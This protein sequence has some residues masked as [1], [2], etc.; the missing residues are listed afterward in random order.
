MLRTFLVTV[1]AVVPFQCLL[2]GEDAGT[3][4]KWEG[5]WQ[6]K[7][8]QQ[9]KELKCVA[10]PVGDGGWQATF[11]GVCN[12]RFSFQVNMRGRAVGDKVVF[13]GNT[14]LG[15]ENGGTYTWSGSI[16]G[17]LFSGKYKSTGGK[18]GTF[19]MKPAAGPE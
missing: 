16:V 18:Q 11:T 8:S 5:T 13:E 7:G 12:R 14:E 17:K 10:R 19:E 15:E 9:C 6:A 3:V 4:D 2:A 1:L